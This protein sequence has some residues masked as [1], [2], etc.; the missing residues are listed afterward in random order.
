[1][2]S[3]ATGLSITENIELAS[4]TSNPQTQALI[5]GTRTTGGNLI[6]PPSSSGFSVP[7]LFV[8]FQLPSFADGISAVNYL[9]NNF[10]YVVNWGVNFSLVL[11]TPSASTLLSNGNYLFT[12]TA[13]PS[14]F[15][16]LLGGAITGVVTQSIT[17][18]G[19]IV[20]SSIKIVNNIAQLA[21]TPIGISTF[22]AGS[23]LSIAGVNNIQKP[24]IQTSD[25]I[26]VE[27]FAFYNQ[28]VTASAGRTNPNA[29]ISVM[30]DNCTTVNPSNEDIILAAPDAV[31][32]NPD[33]STTLTYASDQ[34][35]LG[36]LPTTMLGQSTVTQDTTDATG[37]FNGYIIDSLG[38]VD[39]NVTNVTGTFDIVDADLITITLDVTQSGFNYIDN[40]QIST[41]V[42]PFQ[43]TTL[44]DLTTTQSTF[45]NA[46]LVL[47]NGYA[48]Q[49]QKFFPQGYYANMLPKSQVLNLQTPNSQIFKGAWKSDQPYIVVDGVQTGSSSLLDYTET[50]GS[51]ASAMAYIDL[52]S[53]IP[54][55]SQATVVANLSV[56]SNSQTYPT[57]GQSGDCNQGVIQGW[58]PIAINANGLPYIW[59]NVTSLVTVPNTL[60]VDNQY[61]FESLWLKQRWLQQQVWAAWTV[62][63]QTPFANGGMQLNSPAVR[64]Q[65][66]TN[67]QS[68]L[69]Q[70]GQLGMFQNVNAY[71]GLV[72]VVI[73]PLLPTGF[74]VTIPNQVIP[75]LA[76]GK[77][78]INIFSIYYTFTS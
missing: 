20:S 71:L 39:I 47:N 59:R 45:Y 7:N 10:G 64:Q 26:V 43:I 14:G 72:T 56:N 31:V 60:I 23:S 5:F 6:Q 22:N 76:T 78:S 44:T 42:L 27:V 62:V 8:P 70:G 38:N 73:D 68:I 54:F 11:P 41:Y 13:I 19:N 52:S 15:S 50:P 55:Y 51:I 32:V 61:R 49:Q 18:T 66:L 63:S 34:V 3:F 69:V 4:T 1:M 33:G 30:N 53:Q 21:V 35:G 48:V 16:S 9:V 25:M 46:L 28:A 77:V 29:W 24:N 36:Y 74:D 40:Y 2:N 17:N 58:T 57:T 75:E 12:W 37:T 67:C 65:M